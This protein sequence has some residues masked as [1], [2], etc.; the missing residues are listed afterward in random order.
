MEPAGGL[1][2]R[3]ADRCQLPEFLRLVVRKV[4]R[5]NGLGH[6]KPYFAA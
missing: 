2:H 4:D 1:S 3:N 5:S 6:G